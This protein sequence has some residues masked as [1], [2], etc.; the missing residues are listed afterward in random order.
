MRVVKPLRTLLFVLAGLVLAGAPLLHTHPLVNPTP[1]CGQ[2]MIAGGT[3]PC[4]ACAIGTARAIVVP[5]TL[6][7]P[8]TTYRPFIVVE[9]FVS[10][11]EAV[12]SLSSRAPPAV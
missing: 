8:E 3:A 1:E 10:S 11:H 12:L 7:A 2:S 5:P 4:S 6:V 9:S